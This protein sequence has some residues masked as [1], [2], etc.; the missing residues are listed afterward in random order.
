[1]YRIKKAFYLFL[2]LVVILISWIFIGSIDNNDYDDQGLLDKIINVPENKNG[3]KEVSYTQNKDFNLFLGDETKEKLKT[4]IYHQKWDDEFVYHIISENDKHIKNVISSTKYNLF[5]FQE[6]MSIED[7]PSYQ[8]IMWIHRF[9]ILK[10]MYEAKAGRFHDAINLIESAMIFS[11]QVKTE[12]NNQLISHMIGLVMQ[13]ESLLWIHH[14]AVDYELNENQYTSLLNIFNDIPPY[15]EDSFAEVFS[16]EYAFVD[17][18]IDEIIERPFTQR[19]NDYW[20]NKDWWNADIENDYDME[21]EGLPEQVFSF[22]QMLFPRYYVHKNS[23]LNEGAYFYTNLANQAENYCD[24]I[25]LGGNEQNYELSLYDIVKPN[26][27]LEQWKNSA[28]LFKGYYIRRCF[29]HA[30]IESVKTIVALKK[31][32]LRIGKLPSEIVE[33]VPDYL[34]KNPVDPFN[35]KSLKY[36]KENMWVYSVGD[37]FNDDSG[38]IEAYYIRR[39]EDDKYCS[40]NPTFPIIPNPTAYPVT[41]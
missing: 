1:M 17:N 38:A 4:H 23:I 24:K 9:V 7:I 40:K 28:P 41:Y 14:L 16:G 31:Y 21:K 37:N 8:P 11:Q 27:M 2:S 15:N 20:D 12:S 26:S 36:S 29:G 39:C 5:Q 22:L 18:L 33:L 25:L 13:Y 34:R 19:W 6:V 30:Y 32:E 10:S 3:F 35:G